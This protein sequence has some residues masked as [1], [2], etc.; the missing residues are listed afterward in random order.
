MIFKSY[1]KPTETELYNFIVKLTKAS[2]LTTPARL[3]M[4][5][6]L[7]SIMS[8]ASRTMGQGSRPATELQLLTGRAT[9]KCLSV[10]LQTTTYI[11]IIHIA[12]EYLFRVKDTAFNLT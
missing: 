7:T 8:H 6:S 10:S 5:S 4:T 2:W 12:V 11:I 9:G 3:M 1:L